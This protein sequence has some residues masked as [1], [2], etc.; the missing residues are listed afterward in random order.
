ML[1]PRLGND[2]ALSR[3]SMR[4]SKSSDSMPG[5]SV[6][7][8]KSRRSLISVV[9]SAPSATIRKMGVIGKFRIIKSPR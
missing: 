8:S 4:S 9:M 1:A 3:S 2:T 5:L 6:V 7:R